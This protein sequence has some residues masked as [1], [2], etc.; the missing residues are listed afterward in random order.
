MRVSTVALVVSHSNY[1]FSQDY[2]ISFPVKS[3]VSVIN[4]GWQS[5]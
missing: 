2:L 1:N 5:K 3:F 4:E